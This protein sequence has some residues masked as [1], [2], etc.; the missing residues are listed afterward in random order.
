M[1]L[2]LQ[3]LSH[4]TIRIS[5]RTILLTLIILI[6]TLMSGIFGNPFVI[7][8]FGFLGL[9]FSRFYLSSTN[10]SLAL[11]DPGTG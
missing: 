9:L 4:V 8:S 6:T 2:S 3:N 11:F 1:R 10:A 5:T 7:L